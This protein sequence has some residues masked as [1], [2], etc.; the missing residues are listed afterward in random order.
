MPSELN[1][2]FRMPQYYQKLGDPPL[3]D[4]L[5]AFAQEALLQGYAADQRLHKHVVQKPNDPDE[6]WIWE[7]YQVL[8]K[9]Y[10]MRLF[11]YLEL[12]LQHEHV[13]HLDIAEFRR[14]FQELATSPRFSDAEMDAWLRR[15]FLFEWKSNAAVDWSHRWH[16]RGGVGLHRPN[17]SDPKLYRVD[18]D[19]LLL[20][21]RDSRHD[22][23]TYALELG[24]SFRLLMIWDFCGRPH[25]SWSAGDFLFIR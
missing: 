12:C 14:V 4:R 11:A 19:L 10:D 20:D 3:R 5:A 16:S 25:S 22:N 15:D 7:N 6:A 24:D 18:Q 23:K 13:R 17:V 21:Y 8:F 9:Y 2:Y 1:P